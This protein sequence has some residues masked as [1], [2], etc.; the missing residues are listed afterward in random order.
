MGTDV[1]SAMDQLSTKGRPGRNS[2]C[3]AEVDVPR[4]EFSLMTGIGEP[5]RKTAY[6]QR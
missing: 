5:R 6:L 2:R 4:S 1:R 3:A